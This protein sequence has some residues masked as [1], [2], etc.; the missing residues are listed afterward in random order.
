MLLTKKINNKFFISLFSILIIFT[1]LITISNYLLY[2]NSMK[3]EIIQIHN[4]YNEN[5]LHQ[6]KASIEQIYESILKINKQIYS[7]DSIL[8]L[9][10]SSDSKVLNYQEKRYILDWLIQLKNISDSI[11]S[12]SL[13]INKTG[14][15]YDTNYGVCDYLDFPDNEWIGFKS[16]NPY[17]IILIDRRELKDSHFNTNLN[18]EVLSIIYTLPYGSNYFNKI[19]INVDIEKIYDEAM[20]KLKDTSGITFAIINEKNNIILGDLNNDLITELI[21]KDKLHYSLDKQQLITEFKGQPLLINIMPST[22]FPWNFIWIDSKNNV[23]FIFFKL[24]KILLSGTIIILMLSILIAIFISKKATKPMD[25]LLN[26][27]SNGNIGLNFIKGFRDNILNTLNDNVVMLEK[28]K[29]T[30]PLYKER[31]LYYILTNS[32]VNSGI[33]EDFNFKHDYFYVINV[34]IINLY[35]LKNKNVNINAIKEKISNII[36]SVFEEYN[37]ETHIV[38]MDFDNLAIIVNTYFD[39]F[40][41]E[42]LLLNKITKQ[43][44]SLSNDQY[45]IRI[46]FGISQKSNNIKHLHTLYLQSAQA[47]RHRYLN[48]TSSIIFLDNINNNDNS[49]EVCLYEL[50]NDIFKNYLL[51]GNTDACLKQVNEILDQMDKSQRIS[52]IE[53]EQFVLSVLSNILHVALKNNIDI[54]KNTYLKYDIWHLTLSIKTVYAAKKVLTN[55]INYTCSKI[56]KLQNNNE[57]IYLNTILDYIDKHYHEDISMDKLS[58]AINLSSSYIYKILKNNNKTF[59][60]YLTEKRLKAACDLLHTDA[61]IKEIAAKVGFS[62]SKYFIYVFK[63]YKGITPSQYRKMLNTNK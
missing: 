19:I 49:E 32:K 38:Y 26:K 3:D 17:N 8:N 55:I 37:I 1:L 60:E 59:I 35:A 48:K 15:I 22:L 24:K 30:S 5:L 16:D 36:K 11:Y 34:E 39:N 41:T 61:K 45:N 63:K 4:Q 43:I 21:N 13:Y 23:D 53:F 6:S 33:L 12:V 44:V 42:E 50:N 28:I 58:Q 47:L 51:Q 46:A 52:K 14:K 31:I 9:I 57:K 25:E 27:I 7:N 18:H 54:S 56:Q 40:S 2:L 62:N 29:K 10:Q 20:S